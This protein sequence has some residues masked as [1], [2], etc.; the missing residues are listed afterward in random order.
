MTRTLGRSKRNLLLV[1]VPTRPRWGGSAFNLRA[2]EE[3]G[4]AVLR[5]QEGV[6]RCRKGAGLL[7]LNKPAPLNADLI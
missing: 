4:L 6:R 1:R 5:E 7:P 3:K 2:A